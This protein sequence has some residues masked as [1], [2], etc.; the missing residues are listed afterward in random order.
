MN[1]VTTFEIIFAAVVWVWIGWAWWQRRQAG[2]LLLQVDP[3]QGPSL[4]PVLLV[5]MAVFAVVSLGAGAITPDIMLND[6][7]RFLFTST[8]G[9]AIAAQMFVV[10]QLRQYGI[11]VNSQLVRWNKITSYTWER[12]KPHA[13]TL[14][15]HTTLPSVATRRVVMPPIYHDKVEALLAEHV[16]SNPDKLR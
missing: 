7:G 16:A 12:R 3:N 13:L 4:R 8:V 1:A 14:L 11:L 15:L 6:I 5:V 2:A 10:P 9:A